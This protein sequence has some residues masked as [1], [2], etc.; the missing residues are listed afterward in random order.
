[1]HYEILVEDMSGKAMLD[2]LLPKIIIHTKNTFRVHAYKG[3]G[4]I[5]R[6]LKTAHGVSNRILL[7]QLP[8]LLRGYGNVHKVDKEQILIVVCDLDDRNEK[9]FLSELKSLSDNCPV[10][11]KAEFCLAIE[12]GEAWLLG[13]IAAIKQAYPK[14]LDNVLLRY[15]NDSICGTWELLADALCK[16]GHLKLKKDGFQAIGTQKSKWASTIAPYMDV[17]NNKS[18]SFNNFK[19]TVE[20][21]NDAR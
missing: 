21:Y 14:A 1:M 12:E 9:E 10:K 17:C 8:R 15:K 4:I 2:N 19:R 7:E 20:K 18:P 13:D 5:P 6:N 11:P 3:L 16:G